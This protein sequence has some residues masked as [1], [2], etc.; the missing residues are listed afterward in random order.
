MRKAV[1]AQ[2][3][4]AVAKAKTQANLA[5]ARRQR[6]Y[7][8]DQEARFAVLA[9]ESFDET[10]EEH[11]EED[12]T[13]RAL[14]KTSLDDGQVSSNDAPVYHYSSP[15]R[16]SSTSNKR[17]QVSSPSA[18]Y[19]PKPTGDELAIYFEPGGLAELEVRSSIERAQNVVLALGPVGCGTAHH[20]NYGIF[21]D[22]L[23]KGYS[24]D[25]EMGDDE[26]SFGHEAID[27]S[28]LVSDKSIPAGCDRDSALAKV[29]QAS[30]PPHAHQVFHRQPLEVDSANV[31]QLVQVQGEPN[32][33]AD[34]HA[35]SPPKFYHCFVYQEWQRQDQGPTPLRPCYNTYHLV[36]ECSWSIDTLHFGRI[37]ARPFGLNF[38]KSFSHYRYGRMQLHVYPKQVVFTTRHP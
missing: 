19:A 38:S 6:Q 28:P 18:H 37:E 31:S 20:P 27:T 13:R 36:S 32:T 14:K 12:P 7:Y 5:E 2:S 30:T 21:G 25:S 4:A 3:A 8:A 22:G 10:M 11:R 15:T 29:T 9:S 35:M 26:N 24:Q 23:G 17:N 1:R 33:R 16:Q 34:G